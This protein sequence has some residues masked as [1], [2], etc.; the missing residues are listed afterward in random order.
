M[1]YALIILLLTPIA[2]P[3][4]KQA[5]R[6]PDWIGQPPT[7]AWWAD[8][9][10][11]IYFRRAKPGGI[12]DEI[13]SLDVETGEETLF[14]D[15]QRAHVPP[16]GG[17]IN[18]A[19]TRRAWSRHGDLYLTDL[20][21][22]EITRLTNSESWESSPRFMNDN[23]SI[24]FSRDGRF[25]IRDLA[26][27]TEIDLRTLA[28]LDE[29][30]DSDEPLEGMEAQQE[31]LFKTLRERTEKS[32]QRDAW[33]D[34]LEEQDALR[35]EKP[36][37]L[38]KN[39]QQRMA[40][41]SPAGRWIAVSTS[42]KKSDKATRDTMPRFVT[43]SGY[44]E[45]ERVRP[46]VGVPERSGESL[47]LVDLDSGTYFEIDHSIL[48]GLATDPLAWLD[49][50]SNDNMTKEVIATEVVNDN[51][52]TEAVTSEVVNGNVTA[53]A[54]TSEAVNDNATAHETERP[55][56]FTK[57][58]WSPDGNRLVVQARSQDAK[59]RWIA[60]INF[61]E[62]GPVLQPMHHLHDPA[63][64]SR[65]FN[66]M[67]WLRDG[68]GLWFQS[69]ESGWGHIYL[70]DAETRKTRSLTEGNWE[71]TG[72]REGPVDGLLWFT[73]GQHQPVVRD[74]HVVDP[75]SSTIRQVTDLNGSV[76][77]FSLAPDGSQLAMR[78]SNTTRPHEIVL[79]NVAPG[80]QPEWLTESRTDEYLATEL[81]EPR[82]VR[83]PSP[84]ST[85][86][87]A[88]L[89][90]PPDG[91]KA[92]APAVIFL[93]GAGYLQ[94]AD[95]Q[96]SYYVREA[97]FN[98]YLARQGF[99]VVDLDYRAS[100]G[101]GR[102]WRTATYRNMGS[103]EVEDI[104]VT[105]DWLAA[106]HG[107]DP[108]RVGAYG[109]SYGGFLVLMTMFTQPDLLACGAALRPVTDWAH[110]ADSWTLPIL[111]T[112][113]R[114]PEA[115]LA[116]SPIEHAE[117]LEAPLLI[118]HGMVDNNVLF[119]DTVRLSQRLIELEKEDWEVAI[120]PLEAHGFREDSSWLDEYRRINALFQDIL[121][122]P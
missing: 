71:A 73:A 108:D 96:W 74:V 49:E 69:E 42:S 94:N 93:H 58:E 12:S 34:T 103:P 48:P 55:L 38:G 70:W 35:R 85:D 92:P 28:Y 50:T 16:A 9:G 23:R 68:S 82:I 67:D 90:L 29:E 17:E 72:V 101:Y 1:F 51:V 3:D 20:S 105:I 102:D 4:L 87:W 26:T 107:V 61:E 46:N 77:S 10:Q 2:H 117:G 115:Y 64:I 104:A 54:V 119:K 116:S 110:Y 100:S 40:R 86:L 111:N 76:D 7:E 5:M 44:V 18:Y 14:T 36:I 25:V 11:T 97:L 95:N 60:E 121:N 56:R 83:I 43:D 6:D 75:R 47:L 84:H 24:Q 65:S 45:T 41:L 81:V 63:W 79:Q 57:L 27:N 120:Y 13:G 91:V 22:G 98:M 66:D 99:V 122:S 37:R 30:D 80:S 118:C 19:R 109:G 62:D 52:T 53:E 106:N 113:E 88:K 112:P 33:R 32:D 59:D 89:Y 114:D 78:F 31:R 39:R 21:T 15:A 8:D